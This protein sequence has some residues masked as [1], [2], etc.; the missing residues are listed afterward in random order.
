MGQSG[1]SLYIDASS[2]ST[3]SKISESTGN[4][5]WFNPVQTVLNADLEFSTANKW[6]NFGGGAI[7][8]TGSFIKSGEGWLSLDNSTNTYTGN[9]TVSG[10]Y[11]CIKADGSLGAAPA[12]YQAD[13][14]TLRDGSI[15]MN[16]D[17]DVIINANRGITL[18]NGGGLQAGWDKLLTIN[19]KITG[20]GGLTIAPD[21]GTVVLADAN[22][23]Y[24]GGTT[25]KGNL[26]VAALSDAVGSSAIGAG[27]IAFDGG[28]LIYSGS[29]A[30]STSRAVAMIGDGSVDIEQ[31]NAQLTLTAGIA[32]AGKTLAKYGDGTLVLSGSSDNVSLNIA[33]HEGTIVLDKTNSRTVH[34]AAWITAIDSGA[35]VKLAGSEDRQIWE[36]GE[37]KITGGTFELNGMNH[38]GA[39]FYVNNNGSKISES[40]GVSTTFAPVSTTL[41]ANLE[42]AAAGGELSFFNAIS[43][44]GSITKTGNGSLDLENASNTYLGKTIVKGGRVRISA[45]GCLGAAPTSEAVADQLTLDGGIL[46]NNDS[47]T[48]ITANRGITLGNAGG[49]LQAGW[50]GSNKSLTINSKITGSGRLSIAQD[51][52]PGT[53]YLANAGNDYTGG[54]TIEQGGILALTSDGVLGSGDVTVNGTLNLTS[55]SGGFTLG[56]GQSLKGSGIVSLAAGQALTV[57]G[58][59]APGNSPGTLTLDGALTLGSSNVSNFQVNGWSSGAYDLVQQASSGKTVTFGGSLN[60]TFDSNVDVGWA[61]IFDFTNYA[62][63]LAPGGFAYSGLTGGKT[64]SFDAAT[65]IL[66]VVPEPSVLALL[67]AG[68]LG[69]LAYAW[70]KRK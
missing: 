61:K 20:T 24:T 35:T 14:L 54:T 50:G 46:M 9:T 26:S 3:V 69:L 12:S 30:A 18:N 22:N 34:A 36:G 47:N 43:G 55:K 65:G 25:I 68:L 66:T 21:S 2:G 29:T 67:T 31:A 41:N 11:L 7:S 10:G 8:G 60:V 23:D 17:T 1:V 44:E 64:A 33:A 27:G 45:D 28:R 63:S 32:G 57:N 49:G 42:V 56:S 19:S 4:G 52:A 13:K 16:S 59:L 62:G 39:N 70:R 53:V 37:V 5:G 6:T 38:D 15:L 58:G 40:T 48:V 51:S